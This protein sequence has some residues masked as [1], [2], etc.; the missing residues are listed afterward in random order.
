MKKFI[1]ILFLLSLILYSCA[2]DLPI[3]PPIN[4]TTTGES[5]PGKFIWYDLM[6][7]DIPAV[8]SFYGE[9]FGWEFIDTGEPENNYTVVLHNGIPVEFFY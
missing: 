1:L 5:H 4:T 3:V 2:P 9:L 7:N 8:K 6:T